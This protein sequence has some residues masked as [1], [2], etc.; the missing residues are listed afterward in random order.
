GSGGSGGSA[1][2]GST[3][4]DLPCAHHHSIWDIAR[5]ATTVDPTL[6]ADLRAEF[7]SLTRW[8]ALMRKPMNL[9]EPIVGALPRNEIFVR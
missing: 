2:K 9:D 7:I 3:T 5:I 1:R 8:K 4:S 6:M